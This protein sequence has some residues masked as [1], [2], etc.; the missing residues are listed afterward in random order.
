RRGLIWEIADYS[1]VNGISPCI[2]FDAEASFIAPCLRFEGIQ[3][4]SVKFKY[5][6]PGLVWEVIEIGGR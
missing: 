2:S 3:F 6:G 5:V 1:I 4:D